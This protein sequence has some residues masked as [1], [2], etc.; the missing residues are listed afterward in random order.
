M[1]LRIFG[2]VVSRSLE[3]A[4]I[5]EIHI[6]VMLMYSRDRVALIVGVFK[7]LDKRELLNRT[8]L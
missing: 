1:G 3:H 4:P 5:N 6:Y 8:V 7:T 2:I